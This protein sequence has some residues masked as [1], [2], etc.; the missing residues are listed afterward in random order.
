MKK[1]ITAIFV[2]ICAAC[3]ALPS[4]AAAY[5]ASAPSKITIDG[6]ITEGEW[7]K[8]IY[9]R[10]TLAQAEESPDGILRAWWFDGDYEANVSFDFYVTNDNDAIYI[11]VVVHNTFPDTASTGVN[12]WLH[13]NVTFS[14]SEFYPDT[15]VRIIDYQGVPYEAYSGYRMGLLADGTMKCE[16]RV[17]GRAARELFAYD[18]YM[19][20]YDSAKKTLTY[21][22]ALPL[23]SAYTTATNNATDPKIAV[24]AIVSLVYDNNTASCSTD[25][26]NRFLIGL[27]AAR[28]GGANNFAHRNEAIVVTLNTVAEVNEALGDDK[29]S[30]GTGT[31]AAVISIDPD[32]E[33]VPTFIK[34]GVGG[35]RQTTV[36]IIALSAV[37]VIC[38]TVTAVLLLKGRKPTARG[39]DG[40]AAA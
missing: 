29:G 15:T 35:M 7:G 22:V 10:V 24:S 23:N 14:L 6:V 33:D 26:S 5:H 8:P 9:R 13:H 27:G 36:W 39:K 20:V 17:Q 1:M 38:L 12:L 32:P 2:L 34:A 11:G 21:E 18:D 3:L 40:S 19:I 30:S 4:S 31:P 28:S 16:P 37:I 25:G